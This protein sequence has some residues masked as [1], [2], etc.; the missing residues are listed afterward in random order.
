MVRGRTMDFSLWL[1]AVCTV[2]RDCDCDCEVTGK[3]VTVTVA[4]KQA[5]R[6]GQEHAFPLVLLRCGAASGPLPLWGVN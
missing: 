4:G 1:G 3:R 5:R 6:R 2:T